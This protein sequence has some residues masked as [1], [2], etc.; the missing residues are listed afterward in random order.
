[1][2]SYKD[3]FLAN[4]DAEIAEFRNT[5]RTRIFGIALRKRSVLYG[6]VLC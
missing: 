2:K 1:M 5:L 3:K 4:L 6:E